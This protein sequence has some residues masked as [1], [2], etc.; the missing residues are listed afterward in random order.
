MGAVN[1]ISYSVFD[2]NEETIAFCHQNNITVEAYS[3]LGSQWAK[4]SVFKDPTVTA[5][6]KA[7]N[8][9]QAQ[10]ALK[11]IVQRGDTLAVLSSNAQHQAND[12]DLWSFTLTDDEMTKL[13]AIASSSIVV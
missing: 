9:S 7:H 1:Q 8:V 12:A 5:I 13:G 10:V 6:A 4:K 3:P 2:H 11:W